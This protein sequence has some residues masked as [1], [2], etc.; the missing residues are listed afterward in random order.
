MS[1]Q[2][3]PKVRKFKTRKPCRGKFGYVTSKVGWLNMSLL[4]IL[5]AVVFLYLVQV[6]ASTTKGFEISKLE[7]QVSASEEEVK[8]SEQQ[9]NN[10]KSVEY[11]AQG[12]EQLQMVSVDKINFMP[13]L[14]SGVALGQ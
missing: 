10:L 5:I 7:K 8:Q 14:S 4:L 6:S 9:V 2:R 3:K 1:P 12:A 11:I 13:P